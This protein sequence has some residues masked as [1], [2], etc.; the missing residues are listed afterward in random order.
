MND[1]LITAVGVIFPFTTLPQIFNI[2]YYGNASGVSA[3]TWLLYIL[4]TVILLLYAI[5]KKLRPLIISYTLWLVF[6]SLVMVGA[7]IY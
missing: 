2:W 5:D 7:L 1:K 4:C 3:L 6:D